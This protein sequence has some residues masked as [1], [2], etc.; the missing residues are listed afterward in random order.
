M[1]HLSASFSATLRVRL[2]DRP[3]S[4]AR[5]A[6]AIGDA[7]GSLGAIDL[8]RVEGETKI[9]DV[10]VDASDTEHLERIVEA[11]RAIEG[12]E[13]ERV[14]DRTFLMHLGGKIE[15][16]SKVPVRTRDDLSMAYTP[17]V[18]R[19]CTAI[20]ADPGA[21]WNLTIKQNT[22]AV[23]S[24][25]TAVLGLGDIG[26]EAAMPVMEGKALLFKKFGGVDAWPIC[27]A[28]KDTDAIVAAVQAI[29]PGFGGI[30]LEDIS[31][32]RCFEIEARLRKLLDI[33]VFH[34]DQHG[35]AIVVLAALTNSLRVVG[36]KIEDVK[37]V[38]TGAGAA[39]VAV[40]DI[41]VAAGAQRV[42]VCD[43]S[44][45]IW[46]GRPGLSQVKAALSERTNPE[47]EQGS[48]DEVLTGADVFLGLS[49]PGA[50]S[51][52]G[53]SRM[54]DA[55][56]IF[57]MANPTPEIAPEDLPPGKAMVV[58][59]GRSDYPNQINNVLAFPGV[60][61]GALDVR[62]SAITEEMKVA[63][64]QALAAVIPVDE[65]GPEYVIPSVFNRDVAPAVAAAVAEAAERAGVAR[66]SR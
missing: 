44:G 51:R 13:V 60:F 39:G 45:A 54:A 26:P 22:V 21:A 2:S 1:S 4:F 14:S 63:A 15:M 57:A 40:T 19:I 7:G 18:A 23:V 50:V 56:I 35:T 27:L 66:R 38:V 34:D 65:L 25:G 36:K 61:R 5:L 6:Q 29:A 59:T 43:S 55:A 58:A 49:Q 47:L 52:E 3:G 62:A 8:V 32:P 17:G 24:D 9:R 10:T 46:R 37:I 48:A 30:N 33:P 16:R 12:V 28:T 11:V 41:L 20:A 53:I 42:V 31:A 64:G